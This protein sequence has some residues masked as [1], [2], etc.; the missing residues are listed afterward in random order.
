M[1]PAKDWLSDLVDA[2]ASRLMVARNNS[3]RN[4]ESWRK[5]LNLLK[6]SQKPIK[7]G[8]ENG[9]EVLKG[10]PAGISDS[11]KQV[12]INVARGDEPI[13]RPE[14]IGADISTDNVTE[15]RTYSNI[16]YRDC[17]YALL[18]ALYTNY[19]GV[20]R[21]MMDTNHLKSSAQ[22]FTDNDFHESYMRTGKVGAWKVKDTLK[23]KSLIL[24]NKNI[25]GKSYCLSLNGAR[26]CYALFTAPTGK[27]K[28]V[29]PEVKPKSGRVDQDGN[30]FS[31]SPPEERE[32]DFDK[33]FMQPFSPQYKY[34]SIYAG[35]MPPFPHS[36]PCRRNSS[37]SVAQS[38]DSKNAE[39]SELVRMKRLIAL[40]PMLSERKSNEKDFRRAEP[41]RVR[42]HIKHGNYYSWASLRSFT[43]RFLVVLEFEI[44]RDAAPFVSKSNL[45]HMRGDMGMSDNPA[46]LRAIELVKE[47]G[48]IVYAFPF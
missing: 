18:A 48:N 14:T 42:G 21:R 10:L 47:R 2:A 25:N 12:L 11:I 33:S 32:F 23:E 7:W 15:S 34:G 9:N 44:E 29:R 16:K 36:E 31:L 28:E 45:T 24:E 39:S 13:I 37:L 41:I 20:Q 3:H 4:E 35:S 27:F 40:D 19:E 1:P 22:K 8:K 38:S 6:S 17:Q 30:Y 43:H 26:L 46:V 5:A